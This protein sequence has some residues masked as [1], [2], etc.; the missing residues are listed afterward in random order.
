M[1]VSIVISMFIGIG[2]IVAGRQEWL[3]DQK[4]CLSTHGCTLAPESRSNP[5]EIFAKD[6]LDVSLYCPSKTNTAWKHNEDSFALRLWSISYVWQPGVGGITTFVF[7][8]IFS[9]IVLAIRKNQGPKVNESLLS[10]PF[11][12]LW[13]KLFGKAYVDKWIDFDSPEHCGGVK[14][15]PHNPD[16]ELELPRI[17]ISS[18][19]R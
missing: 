4:L 10:I 18:K 6:D 15:T 1:G 9:A 16:V 7:G 2:N 5:F 13:K 11:T 8:I 12:R 19:V 14:H 3:P 17:S